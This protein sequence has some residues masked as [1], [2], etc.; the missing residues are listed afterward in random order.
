MTL[1]SIQEGL[2]HQIRQ[3]ESFTVEQVSIEDF[4]ILSGGVD[5]AVVLEYHEFDADRETYAPKTLFKWRIR[6]NLFVRYTDEV[7][8]AN[9]MA[10]RRDEIITRLLANSTL[11]NEE[12][13]ATALDS[14]PV[15]GQV[16][17]D[18]KV[19]IGGVR[20]LHEWITIEVEELVA[21]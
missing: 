9:D 7:Q 5:H 14:L 8:G 17:D 12:D 19:E 10:N 13:T 20:F 6:V 2:A 3:I 4:T 1:K 18:E 15:S 21:G 16:S 11:A